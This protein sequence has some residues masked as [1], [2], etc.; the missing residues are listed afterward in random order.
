MT[1]KELQSA[2]MDTARRLGWLRAHFTPAETSK[3]WR[4]PVSGD[5]K[6]FPDLVLVRER[7]VFVELK[8]HG[9]R[10]SQEQK[11]W[12][13]ALDRAGAECYLWTPSSWTSGEIE[14]VLR[15]KMFMHLKATPRMAVS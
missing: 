3:G 14:R 10:V 1:E 6:G 15:D 8:G 11:E 2:V 4:T 5:G 13:E 12:L 7:V 9:G